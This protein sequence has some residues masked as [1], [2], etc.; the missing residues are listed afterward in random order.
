MPSGRYL[1]VDIT[2]RVHLERKGSLGSDTG[3]I[4][5]KRKG[6]NGGISPV[7]DQSEVWFQPMLVEGLASKSVAESN[8]PQ[9]EESMFFH[10]VANEKTSG[11]LVPRSDM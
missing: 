10:L 4:K 3:G 6:N 1:A 7:L 2:E 8:R 5:S 9:S 11:D